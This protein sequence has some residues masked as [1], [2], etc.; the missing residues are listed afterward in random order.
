LKIVVE[1]GKADL[2]AR[3]KDAVLDDEPVQ[4]PLLLLGQRVPGRPHVGEFGLS[5]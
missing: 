2:A 5:S 4:Q 1:I 3:A